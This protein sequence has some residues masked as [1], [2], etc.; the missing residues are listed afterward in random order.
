MKIKN[1]SDDS[2]V[3]SLKKA[4]YL[5]NRI[6]FTQSHFE[7]KG[8][9]VFTEYRKQNTKVKF[10]CG[11]S[12]WHVEMI[13]ITPK[14]YFAFKDLLQMHAIAEWVKRNKFLQDD[15]NYIK[16]EILY[17]INLLKFALPFLEQD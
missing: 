9:A 5:L 15:E 8:Y 12:E 6:G 10:M 4:E 1:I 16:S 11:P 7:R 17:F 2:F 13:I 3:T 14:G